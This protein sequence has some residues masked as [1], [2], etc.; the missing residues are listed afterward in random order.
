MLRVARGPH[1]APRCRPGTTTAGAAR[2]R[3][4]DR[5]AVGGELAARIRVADALGALFDPHAARSTRAAG[6]RARPRGRGAGATDRG[7]HPG[8][9]GASRAGPAGPACAPARGTVSPPTRS[10]SPARPGSRSCPASDARAAAVLADRAHRAD[11]RRHVWARSAG[12][13]TSCCPPTATP[14]T[15]CRGPVDGRVLFGG[16]GAPYHFGSR[17]ARPTTGTRRPTRCCASSCVVVPALAGVGFSHRV[18]WPARRCRATGCRPSTTTRRPG[19]AGRTAT[20][21]RG[22]R[23]ATSPAG[24]WPT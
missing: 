6:P 21:G 7:G 4:R 22:S 12:R 8:H 9:R 3:R 1:E 24:S 23:R 11:R 16:R 15:T 10:C 5:G 19:S 20:P 14:S 18:G 2:G 17:I 13:A